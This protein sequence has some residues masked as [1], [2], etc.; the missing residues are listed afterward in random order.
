LRA[1]RSDLEARTARAGEEAQRLRR[2]LSPEQW[3][4]LDRLERLT[5]ENARLEIDLA[6]ASRWS[7]QAILR[8]PGKRLALVLVMMLVFIA[9]ATA[10][11]LART[12][13]FRG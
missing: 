2:A 7:D 4:A 5:L 3:T 13:F 8:S 10:Y 12:A 1:Y 6:A 9:S 11:F